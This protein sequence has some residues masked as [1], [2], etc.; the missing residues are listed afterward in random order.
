MALSLVYDE[1]FLSSLFQE[2]PRIMYSKVENIRVLEG[3]IHFIGP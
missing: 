1:P 3:L 2:A